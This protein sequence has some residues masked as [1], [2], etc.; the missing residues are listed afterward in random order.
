MRLAVVVHPRLHS[1]AASP[2]GTPGITIT[3]RHSKV[4]LDKHCISSAK[5]RK[6]QQRHVV[7]VGALGQVIAVHAAQ[8]NAEIGPD[9]DRARVLAAEQNSECLSFAC[10]Q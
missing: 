3:I 9:V 10:D 8:S 5:L 6:L 4:G 2:P 1:R 7:V